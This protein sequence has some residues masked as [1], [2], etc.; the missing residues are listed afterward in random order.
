VTNVGV[1]GSTSLVAHGL[2]PQLA[3]SYR[4]IP[5]SRTVV[6]YSGNEQIPSWVSLIP[7]LALADWYPLIEQYRPR[8]IV[9]LSSTSVFTKSHSSDESERT[10][11]AE[12]AEAERKLAQWASERSIDYVILRPTLIYGYG[13]DRNVTQIARFIRRFGFFPVCS[14]ARGLRQPIHA[15]DVAKACMGAIEAAH[16]AGR[17]YNIS[18]GETL[19]YKQMVVRIFE[20]L[21]KSPIFL[22]TPL[23]LFRIA[24]PF[25]R[26]VPKF[27]DWSPSMAERMNQD[28]VFDHSEAERDLHL[29]FRP[30]DLKIE[31]VTRTEAKR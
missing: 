8:R 3:G 27:H 23:W 13:L 22:T 11:A 28:L 6:K 15:D 10:M 16:A 25:V 24:G 7:I 30:F 14:P 20:A 5:F 17:S 18:G 26:V 29:H 21:G 9:A 31:D 1:L 19:A 4:V 12:F 2:L